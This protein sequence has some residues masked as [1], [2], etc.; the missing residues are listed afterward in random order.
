MKLSLKTFSFLLLLATMFLFSTNAYP[1]DKSFSK[2]LT[3]LSG[4]NNFDKMTIYEPTYFIFGEDDLKIQISFKYRLLRSLPLYFGFTQKMFWNIYTTSQPFYDINYSPEFFYRFLDKKQYEFRTLDLGVMHFS[5]GK[6][7]LSSRSLN[8]VFVRTSYLTQIQEQKLDVTLAV[9][10]ILNSQRENPDIRRYMG[11]WD[12]TTTFLEVIS[13][14]NQSI[15]LEISL[16]AGSKVIDFKKG[17]YQ[18][19]VIYNFS[20]SN[21]N[22]ALYLQYYEGYLENLLDYDRKHSQLRLGFLLSY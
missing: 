13:S 18:L 12:V 21:I 6:D 14:T 22:P 17:A 9:F 1:E 19:G 5:N 7:D 10:Q 4:S 11:Y 2:R 16:F 15:D 20:L 3:S 8:K